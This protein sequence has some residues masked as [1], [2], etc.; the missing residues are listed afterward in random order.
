MTGI[1]FILL[2]WLVGNVLSQWCDGYVS[3]NIIGMVLL[4]LALCFR[5]VRADKVAPVAKFLL[6]SMALFFVPYGVGLLVSWEVLLSNIWAIAV[7]A[8]L[9]TCIVLVV[10]G[11]L[12]QLIN[13]GR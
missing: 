6:G 13:R 8:I 11:R 7:A 1:F 12:F 4:F 2:F 5:L 10:G 3:G 9:S